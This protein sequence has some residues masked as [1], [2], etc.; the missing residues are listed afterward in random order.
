MSGEKRAFPL[1]LNHRRM[2]R[3]P[4]V[5][6]RSAFHVAGGL[7]I[8]A[9]AYFLSRVS[10]LSTL[11]A[12]AV[13]YWG[14]ELVRLKVPGV[15]L[16]FF[17]YFAILLRQEELSRPTGAGYVLVASFVAFLAF[18]AELAMLAV[19][20]WAAGD[21]LAAAVG[22][23]VG[24]RRLLGRTL[25]GDVACLASCLAI[26]LG[27]HYGGFGIPLV[28]VL[29]GSVSATIAQAV[30]WPVNDNLSMPLFAAFVMWLTQM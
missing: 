17:K 29:A 24:K 20:F 7:S 25:G 23:Y 27:F 12:F 15:N 22:K 10:V 11:G 18:P 14:F 26:G 28:T 9:G 16:W 8:A 6:W 5:V 3:I 21:P 13:L 30:R 1:L 2:L 19:L 4:S